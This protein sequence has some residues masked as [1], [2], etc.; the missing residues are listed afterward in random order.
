MTITFFSKSRRI[1]VSVTML[2][3]IATEEVIKDPPFTPSAFGMVF[4]LASVML[5]VR[6][7]S[8]RPL[9]RK[10]ILPFAIL[11]AAAIITYSLTPFVLLLIVLFAFVTRRSFKPTCGLLGIVATPYAAWTVYVS[12]FLQIGQLFAFN[13]IS[14]LLGPIG[15]SVPTAGNSHSFGYLLLQ[16]LSP[17]L[18]A[19]PFDISYLLPA[20]FLA[21]FGVG[22][23][24][25]V[26]FLARRRVNTPP[27]YLLCALMVTS[28]VIIVSQYPTGTGWPRI[29]IYFAP[30]VGA[31]FSQV[32]GAR[33]RWLS[34]I[35][36]AV[37]L[38]L[39]LPT[40]ASYTPTVGTFYAHY[41]WEWSAG[42]YLELHMTSGE[43]YSGS[44][45]I[46]SNS[47]F[48]SRIL[49]TPDIFGG[50]TG[51]EAQREIT[52]D[53]AAFTHSSDGSVLAISPIF[54]LSYSFLYGTESTMT[55]R[56]I[57][58]NLTTASN[59]VYSN[60]F[61]QVIMNS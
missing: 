24:V 52:S 55:V 2:S 46:T 6:F 44:G 30:F 3:I 40:V 9:T 38:V 39:A 1:A 34:T 29:L 42:S 21:F 53:F 5:L 61:N 36:V 47:S 10:F 14:L 11:D 8:R 35:I 43:V 32:I 51:G 22:M 45:V 60:A 56:P 27:F 37:V 13:I 15:S 7:S 59:V 31:V 49:P 17:N 19:L 48:N 41:Q 26:A 25:W 4:F 57:I 16:V 33:G 54:F 28:V 23:I 20:W 12:R 58:Y 50:L 18:N